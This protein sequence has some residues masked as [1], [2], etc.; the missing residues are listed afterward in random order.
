MENHSTWRDQQIVEINMQN[1]RVE[2]KENILYFLDVSIFKTLLFDRTTRKNII[3]ATNDY[4]SFGEQYAADQQILPTC[5]KGL[6]GNTIRPRSDKSKTEQSA[7]VRDKAEVFTPSWVCNSQNNLID[8]A[9]F[10]KRGVFNTE[11]EKSW[12]TNHDK[13]IFPDEKGK[14]WQDYVKE[15]RLEITCGEAPYLVSRYDNVT[16]ETIPVSERI[17][18]LDRKLRIVSENTDNEENWLFWAKKAVQSV[19]GFDWQGDNV[20]LARENLLFTIMDF[21]EAKWSHPLEKNLKYLGELARIISWNIWQMDGLKFVVPNSCHDE[22]ISDTA[23]TGKAT[24]TIQCEGC[25]KNEPAKHNGIY[26]RIYDWS[27][28]RSIEFYSLCKSG[29]NK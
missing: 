25:K 1:M 11:T 6:W 16:G 22:V 7:R 5:I 27:A 19:Y 8:N 10:G 12:I 24:T 29:K 17:G 3:W 18:L 28:N 13:I 23:F 14:S 15:N 9:W 2:V 4:A 21:Y 20:L 26:C